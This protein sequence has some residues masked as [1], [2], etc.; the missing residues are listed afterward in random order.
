MRSLQDV[1]FAAGIDLTGWQLPRAYGVSADGTVI[2]GGGDNPAGNSESFRAV[3]P[4]P[5]GIGIAACVGALALAIGSKKLGNMF[6]T[7][8]RLRS[9]HRPMANRR[10]S[11]SAVAVIAWK[12]RRPFSHASSRVSKMDCKRSP[13]VVRSGSS[14]PSTSLNE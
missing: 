5:S 11:F 14:L 6:V 1:L 2:V 13:L 8:S 7:E 10:R 12:K 3:V 4:E 9:A